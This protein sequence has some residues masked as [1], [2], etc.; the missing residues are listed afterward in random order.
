MLCAIPKIPSVNVWLISGVKHVS[1][2]NTSL[3]FTMACLRRTHS[4]TAAFLTLYL[5]PAAEGATYRRPDVT[6]SR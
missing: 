2:Q 4:G 5:V 6:F 3:F 1:R